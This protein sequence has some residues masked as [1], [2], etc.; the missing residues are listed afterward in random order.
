[1]VS[2]RYLLAMATALPAA[3]AWA[4]Q[5]LEPKDTVA[6]EHEDRKKRLMRLSDAMGVDAPQF[7]EYLIS[8]SEH[9]LA[10][11]PVDIP[12]LRVIF[13]EKFFFDF[14]RDVVRPEADGALKIIARSLALDPP[15]VT[16]FIAGH[17]DAIGGAAYNQQ[18][19]LRRAR[20]VAA[21]LI[22]RGVNRAQLFDISFGKMVPIA[23]NDT[24]EGRARNRRVEFLF[25]ARP[26]PIAA[27]LVRQ[28]TACSDN[29][30]AAKACVVENRY[31]AES[32]TLAVPTTTVATATSPQAVAFGRRTVVLNMRQKV[33]SFRAP[34]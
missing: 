33:F 28:D 32:V 12:V 17:T 14:N 25:S 1:M 27:W 7:Q 24:E 22:T 16:V 11:Y 29:G 5:I 20:A 26:A 15:D 9:G 2:R 6:L 19:G 4:F 18:L 31:V 8:P 13:S 21:D 10:D 3:P 23:D 30:A 34:E